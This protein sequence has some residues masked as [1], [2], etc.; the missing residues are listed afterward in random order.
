MPRHLWWSA[1]RMRHWVKVSSRLKNKSAYLTL[2]P[3]TP[4]S[5]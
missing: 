3:F 1:R 2:S 5:P 4:P